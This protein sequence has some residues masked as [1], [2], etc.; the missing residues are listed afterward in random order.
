MRSPTLPLQ[1]SP[2]V[3]AAFLGVERSARG[4]KWIERLSPSQA[5]LGAAIA[6]RHNLPEII[7]RLLA[8]R[9]IA[10]DEVPDMLNP[11]IRALCPD[12]STLTDMEKAAER[13]AR[14]VLA[15]ERVAIF[16][17]YDVDG[18]SSSAL[19][20]R[21]LAWH[22]LKARIYIPDRITEGYGP[23]TAAIAALI[24]DGA[25]LIVTADCGSTSFE[26]LDEAAKRGVDVVVADHHQ[27]G[28]NLPP[29]YAVVNPNRQD[30]LSGQGH[31][32]AAGVVFLMCIA[33]QRQLRAKGAYAK[34]KAPD[35]LGWLDIVALATVCDVVPLIGV[36]RAFVVQGLKV[37][38]NRQN[39]G[40]KALCDAAGVDKPPSPYT[41]GFIL[42]PRINAGGR[43]G[44]ASLGARLLAS[45]DSIEAAGIAQTLD[46]LNRERREI[47]LKTVEEAAAWADRTLLD[48]PACPIII[49][50]SPAWHKGL[51]G[52][53]ASR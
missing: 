43:I 23:N 10:L 51:V 3:N 24:D 25:Q 13:I 27:V 46:K 6:Q 19:L 8:A 48:D 49:A 40:L 12:P 37:L 38:R 32:C 28:E 22:G 33:I 18:A 26:A 42:G 50:G 4:L 7:G 31:L 52:L 53:A 16:G 44:D 45:E 9:D 17:D 41:L 30:C 39:E 35:L 15:G 47:E 11:T 1:Q 2:R 21:F 20:H 34:R 14:A 29:A 5:Y 36:N